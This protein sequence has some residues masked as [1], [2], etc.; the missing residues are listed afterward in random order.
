MITLTEDELNVITLILLKHDILVRWGQLPKLIDFT[1]D[2]FD[3]L[4]A[5]IDRMQKIAWL[6]EQRK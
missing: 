5:K 2:D 6:Q 4:V 3:C 1:P